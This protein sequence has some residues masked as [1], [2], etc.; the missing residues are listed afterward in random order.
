MD[1]PGRPQSRGRT[2]SATRHKREAVSRVTQFMEAEVGFSLVGSRLRVTCNS[3]FIRPYGRPNVS[4]LHLFSLLFHMVRL[5]GP[6]NGRSGAALGATVMRSARSFLSSSPR[7]LPNRSGRSKLASATRG[8]RS[9]RK[10]YSSMRAMTRRKPNGACASMP[11]PAR[12]CGRSLTSASSM[13]R[14][15]RPAKARTRR[16]LWTATAF[17]SSVSAE[18]LRVLRSQLETSS[19]NT[20]ATRNT[21]RSEND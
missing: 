8:R 5:F 17:T 11:R 14:T 12:N 4:L 16:R 7:R 20:I 21:G 18:C 2:D 9:P 19:G 10:R 1:H 13:R 3:S 15:R 6:P